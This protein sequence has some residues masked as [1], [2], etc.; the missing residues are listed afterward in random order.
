[1]RGE[2]GKREVIAHYRAGELFA[3]RKGPYKIHL[4]TQEAFGIGPERTE[5]E[6]PLLYHLGADPGESYDLAAERPEILAEMLEAVRE[7][8][9]SM[10]TR[11]SLFD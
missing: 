8:R 4:I 6:T 11:P 2:P 7:H 5:H 1:M 3:L 9:A 10:E